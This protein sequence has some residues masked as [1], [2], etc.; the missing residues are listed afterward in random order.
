[1]KQKLIGIGLGIVAVIG[2]ILFLYSFEAITFYWDDATDYEYN[3]L[4]SL[5]TG[6]QFITT[7]SA[8]AFMGWYGYKLIKT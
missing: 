7:L 4:Y 5:A 1:M 8:F 3:L 2:L 6:G